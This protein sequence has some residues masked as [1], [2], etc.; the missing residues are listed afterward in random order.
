VVGAF[1]AVAIVAAA[2]RVRGQQS[3]ILRAK[4]TFP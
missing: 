2:T 4:S 3:Q 1:A